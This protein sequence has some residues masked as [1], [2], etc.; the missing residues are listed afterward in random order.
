MTPLHPIAFDIGALNS[1]IHAVAYPLLRKS[2]G[3]FLLSP[4]PAVHKRAAAEF[5]RRLRALPE[6]LP[7][8]QDVAQLLELELSRNL[9]WQSTLDTKIG[10]MADKAF[11]GHDK[12]YD[13]LALTRYANVPRVP[14]YEPFT[15]T[16]WIIV[17]EMLHEVLHMLFFAQWRRGAFKYENSHFAEETSVSWWSA[18]VM[19][20]VFPWLPQAR[21]EPVNHDFLFESQGVDRSGFFLHGSVFDSLTPS[22]GW[23]IPLID[24]LPQREVYITERPDAQAYFKALEGIPAA[25]FIVSRDAVDYRFGVRGA[26]PASPSSREGS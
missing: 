11:M 4:L 13:R 18:K 10:T 12:F 26:T 20:A 16:S 6:R 1:I 24:A 19:A 21:L 9:V 2:K 14:A 3:V 8:Y 15:T 25:G 7:L 5:I 17:D 22:H 23:L